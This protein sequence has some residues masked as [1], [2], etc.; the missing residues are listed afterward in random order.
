MTHEGLACPVGVTVPRPEP[1]PRVRDPGRDGKA[2]RD[3]LAQLSAAGQGTADAPVLGFGDG[4]GGGGAFGGEGVFHLGGQ[5]QQQEG[6]AAYGLVGGVDRQR[7]GQ[8]RTPMPRPARSWTR[9]RTSRRL[10]QMRSRVC[11]TIVSRVR[12]LAASWVAG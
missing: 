4:T 10:R 5:R 12:G 7:A 3:V 11:I 2:A 9:L 1:V 6:D 8:D